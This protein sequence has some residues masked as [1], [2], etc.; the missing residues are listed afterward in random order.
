MYA[1]NLAAI[2]DYNPMLMCR[3]L[4]ALAWGAVP[5]DVRDEE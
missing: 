5:R 2:L 1:I 3:R 4:D